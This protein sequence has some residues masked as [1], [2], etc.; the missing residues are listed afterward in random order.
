MT[1]AVQMFLD[2]FPSI[3]TPN[4]AAQLHMLDT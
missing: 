3:R 1:A 4:T 2:E